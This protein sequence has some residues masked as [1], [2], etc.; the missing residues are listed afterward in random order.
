MISV[1]E[2]CGNALFMENQ[3]RQK[4]VRYSLEATFPGGS[5]EI[6]H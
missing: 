5:V 2:M 1:T 3:G 4:K 6:Y